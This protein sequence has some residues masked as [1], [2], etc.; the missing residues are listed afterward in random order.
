VMVACS[1]CH[2]LRQAALPEHVEALG[3]VHRGMKVSHGG[4]RCAACHNPAR[5]DRLRLADGRQLPLAEAF[6]LC[7]QCHG[8]QAR[9][10]TNGSHGGMRGHWDRRGPAQRNHCI[11]CHDAHSPQFPS[12]RPAP[13]P[14]DRF[15]SAAG[16][17]DG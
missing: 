13:P 7:S 17:H 9:D 12:F 10:W 8:P 4:L 1:T 11:D 5:G 6:Q 2:S 14:R 15:L 16:G 3:P